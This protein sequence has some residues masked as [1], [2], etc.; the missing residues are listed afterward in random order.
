M[1]DKRREQQTPQGTTWTAV[2][3]LLDDQV[4]HAFNV[5]IARVASMDVWDDIVEKEGSAD[6]S[7]QKPESPDIS[8]PDKLVDAVM[9]ARPP[10][11][12]PTL[13]SRIVIIV[14]VHPDDGAPQ[15]FG[16]YPVDVNNLAA[17][18]KSFRNQILLACDTIGFPFSGHVRVEVLRHDDKTLCSAWNF[19]ASV[20]VKGKKSLAGEAGLLAEHLADENE[21]LR[22]ANLQMFIQ[23]SSVINA[24]ANAINAMRGANMPPPWMQD[25][26]KNEEMPLWAKMILEAGSIALRGG[27][28]RE[29][30]GAALSRNVPV[31]EK[32]QPQLP[33]AMQRKALP[34]PQQQKKESG[35]DSYVGMDMDA[36]EDEGPSDYDGWQAN[37]NDVLDDD[38]DSLG[39]GPACK[40]D[41]EDGEER[42]E[43]AEND[44]DGQDEEGNPL[45]DI[46]PDDLGD[47]LADYMD[48]CPDKEAVMRIGVQLASKMT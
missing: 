32:R 34:G 19:E 10:S 38:F 16:P 29:A 33:G 12:W 30:A 14:H 21:K 22:H 7:A 11:W 40:S 26:E 4:A 17:A 42:G 2:V 20:G 23:S 41:E 15:K 25:A 28:M 39:R 13:L 27:N 8:E 47:L 35:Y 48:K 37:E 9:H 45:L 1:K 6:K 18:K 3:D 46:P 24:S 31:R 36:V 44:D 5:A 43:E